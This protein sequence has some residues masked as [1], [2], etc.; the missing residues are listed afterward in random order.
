MRTLLLAGLFLVAALAGC[1]GKT[2][3][4][5]EAYGAQYEELYLTVADK[6]EEN[7]TPIE[8]ADYD[9]VGDVLEQAYGTDPSDAASY[10]SLEQLSK[11]SGN[12]PGLGN[13]TAP[14]PAPTYAW[15][16]D[17]IGGTVTT[18]MVAAPG[19]TGASVPDG[20]SIPG[21][22]KRTFANFTVEATVPATEVS[23]RLDA[24]D[25]D[26][27]MGCADSLTETTSGG[28]ATF[29]ID[30]PTSGDWTISFFAATGAFSG[31]W[32]AEVASLVPVAPAVA[33]ASTTAP[34][35]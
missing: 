5:P 15:E 29:E 25:C 24:P 16:T 28:A 30:N 4:C 11:G 3:D 26:D 21:G 13:S 7:G 14:P 34:P 6:L 23:I 10:P 17:E 2:L 22:A 33:V 35:A 20:L 18:T 8:D 31:D 1:T 19:A 9:C 12:L 27:A 32:S